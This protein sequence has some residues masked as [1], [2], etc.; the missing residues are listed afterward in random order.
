MT[1]C[2]LKRDREAVWLESLPTSDA[3]GVILLLGENSS[4]VAVPTAL[5]LAAS[6]LVR[7]I[8]SVTDHLPPVYSPV[9]LSLPAATLGVLEVVRD[10]LVKGATAFVTE[11]QVREV[12]QIFQ[13]LLVDVSLVCYQLNSIDM[14]N[15]F[16]TDVKVENHERSEANC[17][18]IDP[19]VIVSMKIKNENYQMGDAGTSAATFINEDMAT[20][21]KMRDYLKKIN[22]LYREGNDQLKSS[23]F[24]D[25]C[26]NSNSCPEEDK[27]SRK[28]GRLGSLIKGS[29][30]VKKKP[31]S[32]NSK[33]GVSEVDTLTKLRA[34]LSRIECNLCDV[35]LLPS[36]Y[37]KHCRKFHAQILKESHKI[38]CPV[39]GT[40]IYQN[41]LLEHVQDKHVSDSS[42]N[43]RINKLSQVK[44]DYCDSNIS[45]KNLSRHYRN[46]HAFAELKK[47]EICGVKMSHAKFKYHMIMAH[48]QT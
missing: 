26:L 11:E 33:Q 18:N 13:M 17:D 20:G 48:G 14:G 46:V 1:T 9:Y 12:R 27:E 43:E 29:I 30:S 31:V 5:L 15:V 7:K 24:Q 39:C 36:S 16:N 23:C 45:Y 37:L 2:V 42:R 25:K 3:S 41:K 4:T 28:E 6:P 44:C 32:Q 22:L 34:S 8:L 35:K 40:K 21:W 19:E 10:I 47:C 38:S